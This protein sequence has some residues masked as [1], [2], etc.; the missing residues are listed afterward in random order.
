METCWCGTFAAGLC[1]GC[2]SPTC[3]G[4][5][6]LRHDGRWCSQCVDREEDNAAARQAEAA[7]RDE[8]TT[9][10]VWPG[11]IA[12]AVQSQRPR[13]NSLAHCEQVEGWSA[14]KP[15]PHSCLSG[16]DGCALVAETYRKAPSRLRTGR[17]ERE[18]WTLAEIWT[19][20][21]SAGAS[22]NEGS[23]AEPLITEIVLTP[24][25]SVFIGDREIPASSLTPRE[26]PAPT[27]TDK[28]LDWFKRQNID[29]GPLTQEDAILAVHHS[30]KDLA[31]H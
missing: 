30:L 3:D 19:G 1:V 2:E 20:W 11:L 7:R 15:L 23:E 28:G 31:D 26:I 12:A 4:H 21:S 18:A 8:I 17:Y 5:S 14:R 10:R 22:A 13:H 25:G 6:G 24:S 29:P 27:P 9:G 16:H